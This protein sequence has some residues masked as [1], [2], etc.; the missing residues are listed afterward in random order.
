MISWVVP[1]RRPSSDDK[2][3]VTSQ[4]VIDNYTNNGVKD[5]DKVLPN[6]GTIH[7]SVSNSTLNKFA[8]TVAKESSGD[9]N[10]SYA[11]ASAIVNTSEHREKLIQKT[12]ETEGIH[13]YKDGG[14]NPNYKQ[15]AEYSREAS[16]NALTGG[17]DF[18]YGAIRWDG[19]DLAAKGF[20]HIKAK[21]YGIELSED[22]FKLFK[23]AWPDALIKS[24]SGGKFTSFSSDFSSGIHLATDGI[25]K[26]RC[27]LLATGVHGRTV[28]WGINMSPALKLEKPIPIPFPFPHYIGYRNPNEGFNRWKSL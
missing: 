26:G 7:L 5:W 15:N 13:G 10:E 3:Y 27:L 2:A 24:F 8:N 21:T 4:D 9:K 20:G 11:L 6:S 17:V 18:S 22:N 23:D 1:G 14:N 19:F 28:F 16:I 25:N 12:L